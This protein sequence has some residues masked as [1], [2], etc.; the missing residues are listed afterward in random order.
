MLLSFVFTRCPDRTL[1]PAISGKY[2]YIQ[3]HMDAAHVHLVEITLDPPYD[4]PAVLHAY[5]EQ[6]TADPGRWSLLTGQASQMKDVLDEFGISSISDRPGNYV[7]DDRLI[8]AGPDGRIVQVIPTAGWSPDDA[9]AVASDAAGLGSNP[10]RRFEL[11][12]IAGVASLCGGSMQTGVV[13]LDSL[14]FVFGVLLLGS[15]LAWWG[16]RIFAGH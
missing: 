7:H 2:L 13:I 1:C 16:R 15:I 5:G 8:V 4:S 9:L 11:A 14:A 10:L 12:T 3:N 6:F